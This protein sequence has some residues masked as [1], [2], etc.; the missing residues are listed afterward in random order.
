M[1][2]LNE[3][4]CLRK[5]FFTSEEFA[6]RYARKVRVRGGVQLHPYLCPYCKSWHLTKQV[7][8]PRPGPL[9]VPRP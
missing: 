3:D 4:V 9:R 8:A 1:G 2:P 6:A 7:Q 5:M